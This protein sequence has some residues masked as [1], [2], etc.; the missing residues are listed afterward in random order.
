MMLRWASCAIN[1]RKTENEEC[2]GLSSWQFASMFKHSQTNCL[3]WNWQTEKPE[4]SKVTERVRQRQCIKL[5]LSSLSTSTTLSVFSTTKFYKKSDHWDDC[6]NC[7]W[8]FGY[9]K[10]L[11]DMPTKLGFL[12]GQRPYCVSQFK[13][14]LASQLRVLLVLAF[15]NTLQQL[16]SCAQHY[17][18]QR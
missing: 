17:L 8:H 15:S 18:K 9:F 1:T 14:T 2:K 12:S 5:N 13:Q 11:N 16:F 4:K 3:Y 10:W 6:P 7:K